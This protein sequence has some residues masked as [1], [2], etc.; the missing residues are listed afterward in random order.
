MNKTCKKCGIEYPVEH[1]SKKGSGRATRCSKC[2][3]E[4]FR[5]Y[6]HSDPER[7]RSHQERVRRGREK[8]PF[9]DRARAYGISEKDVSEVLSQN[10]G[11]CQIC[12]IREA[13]CIDHCHKTMAI[14]GALCSN[15]NRGIGLLGD[16]LKNLNRAIEYLSGG[17]PSS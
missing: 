16:D 10:G 1:F 9:R 14:R 11:I 17:T 3:A 8:N 13:T 4:Y 7:K 12:N 15:C 2:V 5:E 6:Y